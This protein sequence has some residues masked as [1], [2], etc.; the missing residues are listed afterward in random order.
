MQ[1][2]TP[3]DFENFIASPTNTLKYRWLQMSLPIFIPRIISRLSELP[4][5][6][7]LGRSTAK[8]NIRIFVS[9]EKTAYRLD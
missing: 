2:I 7:D 4:D 8:G 6:R 5:L 3:L 1:V 9:T